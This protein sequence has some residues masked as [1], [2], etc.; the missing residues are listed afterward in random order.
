MWAGG[1]G[2][3]EHRWWVG[4]HKHQAGTVRALS[5]AQ[6]VHRGR[7]AG[8]PD[9]HRKAAPLL[10]PHPGKSRRSGL[11]FLT[12]ARTRPKL[13]QPGQCGVSRARAAPRRGVVGRG[14]GPNTARRRGTDK[15]HSH[16][17]PLP[18]TG[19]ARTWTVVVA[20][21]L[22]VVG[23]VHIV[24]LQPDAGEGALGSRCRHLCLVGYAV[25]CLLAVTRLAAAAQGSGLAST[26]D[27]R[28]V[29]QEKSQG[30][31]CCWEPHL[32]PFTR[33]APS[34]PRPGK[35]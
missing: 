7:C 4:I 24:A 2:E 8:V 32:T 17:G 3:V 18:A 16:A 13:T 9:L 6:A 25:A 20:Q 10:S 28:R 29:G 26:S 1:G 31:Q 21:G 23:G 33:A 34:A 12:P 35:V 22:V 15:T 11:R 14:P 5:R 27:R 30:Q 19:P